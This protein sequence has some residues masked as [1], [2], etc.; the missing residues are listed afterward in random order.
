MPQWAQAAMG[1]GSAVAGGLANTRSSRTAPFESNQTQTRRSTSRT[2]RTL[3]PT[4]TQAMGQLSDLS[5]KLLTDPAAGTQPLMDQARGN[6]N[7]SYDG[8]TEAI[9]SKLLASGVN[10]SG[11][12]GKATTQTEL[13]RVGAL[14]GLEGD[15]ASLILKRQDQGAS[16]A[17]RLLSMNFG[18]ESTDE[19][20]GSSRSWGFNTQPGNAAAGAIGG[21]LSGLMGMLTLDRLLRAGGRNHD[22]L[23]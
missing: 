15:F 2:S 14:S 6:V 21:G 22:A 10:A 19:D 1:I 8:V 5:A 23:M 7:A 3:L 16:L 13:S 17:E 20:S 18:S 4:Q 12:L 11:K 9:R